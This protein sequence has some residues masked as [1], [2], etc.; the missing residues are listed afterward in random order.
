MSSLSA[1]ANKTLDGDDVHESVKSYFSAKL[2]VDGQDIEVEG[3]VCAGKVDLRMFTRLMQYLRSTAKNE[4]DS[5]PEQLDVSGRFNNE[6]Y[7]VEVVG[8][9]NISRLCKTQQY[10]DDPSQMRVTKKDFVKGYPSMILSDLETRLNVKREIDVRGDKKAAVMKHLNQP[11]RRYMDKMYRFKKRFCVVSDDGLFRYDLTIV[12]Q[13]RVS[14]NGSI[15]ESG[16]MKEPDVFEVELEY[17]GTETDVGKIAAAFRKNATEVYMA[18]QDEDAFVSADTKAAVVEEYT[19]LTRQNM[20]LNARYSKGAAATSNKAIFI[21]PMPITLERNNLVPDEYNNEHVRKGYT[22]TDKADGERYLLHATKD[23]TVYLLSSHM[24]VRSSGLRVKT[25]SATANSILDCELITR[26]KDNKPMRSIAIFDCYFIAGKDIGN[27]PLLAPSSSEEARAGKSKRDKSKGGG[28]VSSRLE[29]AKQFVLDVIDVASDAGA[30]RMDIKVKTFFANDIF[31][32]AKNVLLKYASGTIPYHI[33]GLIYTP[34]SLP[35]GAIVEGKPAS[36]GGAWAKVYKW[37]PPEDNSIDFMVK[38]DDTDIAILDGGKLK[39]KLRLYVGYKDQYG[40]KI[41]SLDFLKGTV[42]ANIGKDAGTYKTKAFDLD[43]ADASLSETLVPVAETSGRAVCLNGDIIYKDNIVEMRRTADGRWEPMRVRRDKRSP[44]D[45]YTAMNIWRSMTEPVDRGM[46]TSAAEADK[47][48]YVTDENIYYN[49]V[50]DRNQSA[51]RAMVQFHNSV[52]RSVID[53][54][55]K[56]TQKRVFEIACGKGGDLMKYFDNGFRFFVGIDI[57]KDNIENAKDGACARVMEYRRM[58]KYKDILADDKTRIAFVEM[59]FSMVIDD[60]YVKSLSNTDTQKMIQL[61][62]HGTMPKSDMVTGDM[63]PY[64]NLLRYKGIVST[65]FTVVSCQFA[66]HYFLESR[67]SIESFLKNLDMVLVPGGYFIGT[68][69]DGRLLDEAFQKSKVAKNECLQGQINGR[70]I[71]KVKKLYDSL[72]PTDHS[73]NIGKK[74]EVF[75]ETINKPFEEYVVDFGLL[76]SVLAEHDMVLVTPEAN[77]EIFQGAGNI[78]LGNGS[79]KDMYKDSGFA[80]DPAERDY[81]F[82]NKYFIFQKMPPLSS[83]K[84][85]STVRKDN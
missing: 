26:T 61:M 78:S 84:K 27:L 73:Q 36:Y 3:I 45:Y 50:F 56:I 35:V 69:M 43:G 30:P 31:L 71:W 4:M 64:Q 79:F 60:A 38:Y 76:E 80:L 33:D 17:V 14:N 23:G 63:K 18:L 2:D 12:K 47:L 49:R 48:K 25:P 10:P 28:Q 62:W 15:S 9:K 29:A 52:K 58:D 44:N 51:T 54:V 68:Y 77:P 7:R 42:Y 8:I 66:I 83:Q 6:S 13:K 72:H 82:L 85:S 11:G 65:G 5:L 46:I 75:M 39:K 53:A 1:S 67:E 74:I 24:D 70:I 20:L 55:G 34:A 19:Q 37:K 40:M 57:L 21:G 59:D 32:A 81:S 22:V 41:N 16:V